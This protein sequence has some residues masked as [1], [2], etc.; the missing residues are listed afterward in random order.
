MEEPEP[1]H[2]P[3]L[4][5]APPEEPDV[6][7]E[8]PEAPIHPCLSELPYEPPPKPDPKGKKTTADKRE[9]VLR[10]VESTLPPDVAATL[11]RRG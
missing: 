9:A 8:S 11:R 2:H 3:C 6:Q 4:S 7:E 1:R 10:R 5:I